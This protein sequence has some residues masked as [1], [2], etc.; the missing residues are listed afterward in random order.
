MFDSL[1]EGII[2]ATSAHGIYTGYTGIDNLEYIATFL[3]PQKY[4][5]F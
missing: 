5:L 4:D 1:F 2:K 3:L